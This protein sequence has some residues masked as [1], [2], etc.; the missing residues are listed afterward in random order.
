MSLKAAI[1]AAFHDV[2][3]IRDRYAEKRELAGF[4][5]NDNQRDFISRVYSYVINQGQKANGLTKERLWEMMT[6]KDHYE[7][8]WLS[9]LDV[10]GLSP[11]SPAF[12]AG[13]FRD[14]VRKEI[15]VPTSIEMIIA[16][17]KEY[18]I[19]KGLEL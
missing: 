19:E 8:G 17:S 18:K 11:S 3:Y 16:A 13:L 10:A 2:K 12:V 1:T 9:P 14:S 4:C 6:N 7:S 15:G 5:E